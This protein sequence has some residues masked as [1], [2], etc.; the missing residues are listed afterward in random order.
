M[1]A[2]PRLAGSP[3]VH[4]TAGATQ[5]EEARLCVLDGE[6]SALAGVPFSCS[7]DSGARVTGRRLVHRELPKNSTQMEMSLLP[8][9]WVVMASYV[10]GLVIPMLSKPVYR[11]AH[12]P[13][14]HRHHSINPHDLI[15]EESDEA[16]GN[17]KLQCK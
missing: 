15:Q 17:N 16:V 2:G 1:H 10:T 3:G 4:G 11:L 8:L 6:S 7:L 14:A 12:S 9:N 13:N 5:E